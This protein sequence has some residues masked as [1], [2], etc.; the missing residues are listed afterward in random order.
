MKYC[1]TVPLQ[2]N[3]KELPNKLVVKSFKYRYF[4]LKY[5][6]RMSALNEQKL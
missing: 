3:I 1:S 4:Q 5:F 6:I 2:G